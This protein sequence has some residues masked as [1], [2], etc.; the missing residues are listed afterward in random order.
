MQIFH[1]A[2]AADWRTAQRSGAYTTSTRGRTLE[3]EGFIHCSRADQVERVRR[4]YYADVDEPL[5]L[6]TIDTDRLTVPWREDP[7]GTDTY[8]HL[9][10]PLAPSAVVRAQPLDRDGRT[11]TFSRHLLREMG[12]RI[13]LALVAMGLAVVGSRV[14]AA[15]DDDWG[16]LLGALVGLAAGL[17][18]MAAVLRR[19]R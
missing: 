6:L 9:Y 8:P 16:P 11:T 15:I 5:V 14:G 1:I 18:G 13:G 19:R 7:V 10:G 17:G 4:D 3:E 2:T 12:L